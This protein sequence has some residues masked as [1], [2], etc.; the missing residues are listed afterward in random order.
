M[1]KSKKDIDFTKVSL[2][3]DE[4]DAMMRRA[5]DA[6]PPPAEEPAK[7]AKRAGKAA[8]PAKQKR[9]GDG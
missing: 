6:P 4:F 3:A 8:R 9:T 2:P 7:P 5:L 1:S